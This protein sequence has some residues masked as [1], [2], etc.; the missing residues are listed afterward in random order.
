MGTGILLSTVIRALPKRVE[1]P[2]TVSGYPAFM[3]AVCSPVA[4]SWF[5]GPESIWIVTV[6][7]VIDSKGSAVGVGLGTTVGRTT[8]ASWDMVAFL[9]VGC[10]RRNARAIRPTSAMK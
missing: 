7:F 5:L 10:S 2:I 8:A 6:T 3:S 4:R 9:G 1:A